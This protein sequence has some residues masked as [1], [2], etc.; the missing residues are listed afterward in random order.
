MLGQHLTAC[1]RTRWKVNLENTTP[2]PPPTDLNYNVES[3]YRILQHITTSLP[4]AYMHHHKGQTLEREGRTVRM[5]RADRTW[6]SGIDGLQESERLLA[7]HFSKDQPIRPH[8]QRRDQQLRRR[9]LRYPRAL[10]G[11]RYAV[12][13]RQM[14]FSGVF[15]R[16]QPLSRV[17]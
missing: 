10:G 4:A 6:V 3:S 8:P 13:V 17:G 5:D 14:Q 1:I 11:Q 15:D 2:T 9:P 16:H 7:A 12:L